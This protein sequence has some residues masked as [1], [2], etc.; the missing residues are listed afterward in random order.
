[1]ARAAV[2]QKQREFQGEA[3]PH[4]DF[5][6]NYALRMTF[7]AADAE[8][9][10]QE[11]FLKA[12]RF[13]DSYEK[14]TNIRAWLFRIMKNAFINRYR[15]EK[16]EP[17]TVEYQ[18]VENF[19]NSVRE[20]AVETSDLQESVFKNLLEDE[21]AVAIAELPEDFRTVVILCDIEEL[22]Y[23]EVA[24]FIDCPIGTVRSRLHRGRKLLRARLTEYARKR[25]YVE[26]K[27]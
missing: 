25:G 4:M 22:T 21:V 20:S 2:T 24:E 1:M 18:E 3:L 6:Y 16:K 17:E 13:W 7:N 11:T 27:K 8:D 10:V 5:L 12:F 15:K 9:L 23:E 19:Y 26:E 14:G